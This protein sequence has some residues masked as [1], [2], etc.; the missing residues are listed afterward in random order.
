MQSVSSF[1]K[2]VLSYH[3][4]YGRHTL[5]W[6][7]TTDPYKILVSE[8]MLQQTQVERVIP[9]YKA[10]IKKFPNVQSLA[11]ASLGDV[12]T[13]WV[14]LGYNR[15]AK[16]LY[17]A[18][19]SI[20]VQH[21]GVFPKTVAELQSLPGVGAYTAGAVAAFAYSTPVA[22]LE[23]NIRTVLLHHYYDSAGPRTISDTELLLLTKRVL[24]K[25]HIR[26]WYYALM[27]YGV[28]IKKTYGS[29]NHQ[30]KHYTKQ[31]IFNGSDRQVRGSI[32]RVLSNTRIPLSLVLLKKQCDYSAVSQ[33][34]AQLT[35]LHTEGLIEKQGTKYRLAT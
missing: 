19:R 9:K 1:R 22:M 2:K 26:T 11:N 4:R 3:S 32:I 15:R 20:Y 34:N 16:Y 35:A 14:G 13:L 30:S 33:L 24:P 23:T 17:E 5:P 29:N 28:Y 27:D 31:S 25:Q 8:I 10:F 18:A 6:R 7:K 12:L 21:G